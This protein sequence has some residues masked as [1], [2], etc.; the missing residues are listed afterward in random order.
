MRKGEARGKRVNPD[1]TVYEGTMNTL[2]MTLN[3]R[4]LDFVLSNHTLFSDS[5]IKIAAKQ[6]VQR[7][8]KEKIEERRSRMG[9]LLMK[10]YYHIMLS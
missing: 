6:M 10:R 8:Q 9:D 1:T 5:E 2:I 4:Q 3:R 7:R